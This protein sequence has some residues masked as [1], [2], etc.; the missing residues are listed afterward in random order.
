MIAPSFSRV[1]IHQVPRAEVIVYEIITR[2][3]DM[4]SPG[5]ELPTAIPDNDD[6]TGGGERITPDIR[7]WGYYAHLSI[8][9]F[10][11]AFVKGARVLDAG[12]GTGYGCQHLLHHGAHSVVGVDSSEK[13]ITFAES[14][15]SEPGISFRVMDLCRSGQAVPDSF[16]VV[17]CNIGEHLPDVETFLDFCR[18]SLSSRGL[19][20]LTVPAIA[21]PGI[22]EGNMRNPYHV[23]HLPPKG[24]LAK[25][26]RYF[27]AVQGF[28]HWVAPEWVGLNRFPIEMGLAAN[29]TRIRETDFRF[30]SASAEE[31]NAEAYNICLVT[32]SCV[33]RQIVLEPVFDESSFPD[34]WNVAEIK[35]R[36]ATPA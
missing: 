22:L 21:S 35:T 15:Y 2:K 16:D 5:P 26:G 27:Y 17:F 13:A 32:L 20:V 34:E 7:D 11:G 6:I 10:C 30:I 31:L 24:W 19:L 4:T 18:Q 25:L 14:R 1:S 12:C 36:I 9:S 3:E 8:Y 23:T 28:R 29:E 33:P